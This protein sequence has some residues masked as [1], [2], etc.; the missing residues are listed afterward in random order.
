MKKCSKLFL[1][2]LICISK[3]LLALDCKDIYPAIEKVFSVH[4]SYKSFDDTLRNR[5]ISQLFKIRDPAKRYLLQSDVDRIKNLYKSKFDS[6]LKN[7][8]CSLILDVEKIYSKRFKEVY[9]Q[10]IKIIDS[11]FD[12]KKDEY[13]NFDPKK[14]SYPKN[15]KE[16]KEKLRKRIKYVYKSRKEE[17][18]V[19][20][21]E[22]KTKIKKEYELLKKRYNEETSDD[23]FSMFLVAFTSSLDNHSTYLTKREVEEFRIAM[24]LSLSGIGAVLKSNFGI[25]EI[26][27]L[28]P[29]GPAFKSDKLKAG[30]K[31]IAVAQ[32]GAKKNKDFKDIIDMNLSDVVRKIRGKKKTI[33]SLKIRRGKK[34]FVVALTRAEISLEDGSAKSAL[35]RAN[36][37]SMKDNESLLK[38]ES[39]NL[40]VITLPSFYRN[41][42]ECGI[43]RSTCKSSSSDIRKEIKKFKDK[44]VD[45]I[46]ID[47]RSNGGGALLESEDVAK[48]FIGNGPVVQVKNYDG[49]TKVLPKSSVFSNFN[50]SS[51]EKAPLI[52]LINEYSASASE[53]FAGAIQDYGRGLIIGSK[54]SFGKG[55][56]QMFN[57]IS[58][59]IEGS[60][61]LT[62]QKFY[63][64]S[65]DGMQEKG[66]ASDILLPSFGLV[67]EIGEKYRDFSLSWDSIPGVSHKNHNMVKPYLTKLKS[68][69][70]A[71]IK[72]SSK[73]N[74]FYKTMR[75]VKEKEK[76]KYNIS[77]KINPNKKSNKKPDKNT[78]DNIDT[79]SDDQI[80]EEALRVGVDYV[81]LLNNKDK[82]SS[83][84][85]TITF[86]EIKIKPKSKKVSN[87]RRHPTT[88]KKL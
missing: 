28:I 22:I 77:L 75:E 84:L 70:V 39:Y 88:K 54:H 49:T 14:S 1:L 41:F 25:T 48:I 15:I 85:E 64:V 12:F 9:P 10:I 40:G 69:S 18:G 34:E 6:Q 56:V 68:N 72:A 23:T 29:G 51:F 4:I 21:E 71:R 24:K 43:N 65:G 7:Y 33:V 17:S 58:R 8:N 11:K 57:P 46:A 38:R 59:E 74:D 81:R 36:I 76:E 87:L 52:V 73:F 13:F 26:V 5:V 16:R 55:S 60:F 44:G 2:I 37:N 3:S 63:R 80:L 86:S 32:G 27:R 66:V 67:S 47:L 62:I 35:F 42:K 31:I 83:N 20:E 45:L 19:S 61:K 79:L 53:I 50:T 82:G 78:K 30:D